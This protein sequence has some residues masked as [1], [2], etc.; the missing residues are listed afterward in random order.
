MQENLGEIDNKTVVYVGDGNNI[1]HSWLRLVARI[2]F[3]FVCCCPEGYEPDAATMALANA[4]AGSAEVSHD[5]QVPH[6]DPCD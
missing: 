2:P 5:P 1:V 3:K 6:R 4:G